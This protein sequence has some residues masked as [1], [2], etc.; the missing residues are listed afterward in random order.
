[1][2]FKRQGIPNEGDLVICTVKKILPH[3]AFV[4]LDEYIGMEAMLHISEISSKWIRNIK[5]VITE[6]KKIVC[7]ILAVNQI[8]RLIDV[9][10]KRVTNSEKTRKLNE[11]TTQIKMEK[12]IEVIAKKFNETPESAFK[13]VGQELINVFGSLYEFYDAIKAEGITVLDETK[14]NDKWKTELK[15]QIS[16]QLKAQRVKTSKQIDLKSFA[17]DGITKLNEVFNFIEKFAKSKKIELEI[18]YISA[19]VYLLEAIS[20]NYKEAEQFFE[21][22]MEE[23]EQFT[24]K[25]DIEFKDLGSKNE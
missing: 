16:E 25:N 3:A 22:M 17:S 7:K 4:S 14:T 24:K 1:M 23:L 5:E 9:S 12:L 8:K 20:T 2:Y 13:T 6:G 18:K 21:G 15:N 11:E 10:L 19:P